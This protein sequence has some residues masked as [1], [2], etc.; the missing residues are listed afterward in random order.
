M[1]RPLIISDCDG[2]LLEFIDPFVAYLDEVHDLTLKLTSFALVG[3]IRDK[4]DQPVAAERFPA[5]LD[6]FFT[7]HMPTQT[8]IDGAA[9]GLA[10]LAQDC[11][12]IILTNI[13]DH[14]AVSRTL[15]LA[16]FGMPY[17]VIGNHG[18]KGGP[19]LALLDEFQP[20]AAVFIDDL[21][22]HHSSA[23]ALV[24]HVHRLHMVAEE[25]LRTLIPPA[26]DAHVR[27]DDW[28]QAL[29]HIQTVLKG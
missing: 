12:V 21:P 4:D 11:D 10:T 20:S 6:G 7:T 1:T 23:K 3:N 16:Q 22:P 2:V 15:E 18:P 13:A 14:H 8:P 26:A 24:P 28:H 27:I 17:R 9:H 5:L 25:S 29:A 19:I